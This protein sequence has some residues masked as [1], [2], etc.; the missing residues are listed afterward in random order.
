MRIW[1]VLFNVIS[2]GERVSLTQTNEN[3][4]KIDNY[5]RDTVSKVKERHQLRET[6]ATNGPQGAVSKK[7]Q[8]SVS[9]LIGDGQTIQERDGR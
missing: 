2:P 1:R 8:V 4:V 5:V 7:A 3:V 9:L 6:S